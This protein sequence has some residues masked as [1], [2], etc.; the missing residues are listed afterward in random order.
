VLE[1]NGGAVVERT[2]PAIFW[3][4]FLTDLLNPKVIMFFFAFLPQFVDPQAGHPTLQLLLLGVTVNMV[5]LIINLM[6][7]A[8]SAA[9]TRAL[10]RNASISKWLNRG[11]G[12]LFVALGLRL[13]AQKI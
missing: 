12:A 9:L 3:Q 1:V 4:A 6:L 8:F 10:R 2:Q 13:A 5:C 11:M 7:V